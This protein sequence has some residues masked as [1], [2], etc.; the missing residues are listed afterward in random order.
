MGSLGAVLK[1]SQINNNNYNI[2]EIEL[3]FQNSNTKNADAFM[4]PEISPVADII[5]Q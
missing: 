5:K 4:V 3:I 2:N 1:S